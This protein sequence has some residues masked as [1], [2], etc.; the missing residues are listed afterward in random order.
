MSVDFYGECGAGQIVAVIKLGLDADREAIVDA[1]G[2]CVLGY[3]DDDL[4]A[5]DY[6]CLSGLSVIVSAVIRTNGEAT[7]GE[8]NTALGIMTRND[9]TCAY[10]GKVDQNLFFISR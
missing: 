7:Y 6:F 9:K 3:G 8:V 2:V 4:T 1:R 5:G 10:V